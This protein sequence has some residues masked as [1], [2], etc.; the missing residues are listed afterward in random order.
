MPTLI[1]AKAISSKAINVI[2]KSNV[3]LKS[4][5]LN[6]SIIAVDMQGNTYRGFLFSARSDSDTRIEREFSKK[7]GLLQ[8]FR[9][10]QVHVIGIKRSFGEEVKSGKS[11][12]IDVKTME[13]GEEIFQS[14]L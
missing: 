4:N 6:F 10:Y 12:Q 3:D 8:P 9:S 11:N 7:L 5:W 14:P 2:W 13:G 1:S